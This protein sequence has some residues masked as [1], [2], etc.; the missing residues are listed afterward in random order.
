VHCSQLTSDT[1]TRQTLVTFMA[2]VEVFLSWSG[3]R[4]KCLARYVV[5]CLP[6]IVPDVQLFYSPEIDPGATWSNAI[7]SAIRRS[8]FAIL[9]MTQ[10]NLSSPWL[11]FEAG[12]LWRGATGATSACPLLLDVEPDQLP[13]P[14]KLFQAKRFDETGFKELCKFLGK[15][16]RLNADRLR[17]N[18]KAV[19]PTLYGEVHSALRKL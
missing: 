7:A 12:A 9:C 15:Q 4:S 6:G 19:W 17:Y 16:T 1:L 5:E 2:K 13:G 14:L 18:F 10:E 11:Q 8:R 3:A